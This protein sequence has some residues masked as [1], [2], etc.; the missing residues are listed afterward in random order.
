MLKVIFKELPHEIIIQVQGKSSPSEG[1]AV[2]LL[3]SSDWLEHR[4]ARPRARTHARTHART[5]MQVELGLSPTVHCS[6]V[7]RT[8][9]L[10]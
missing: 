2:A 10:F 8:F 7:V 1:L 6:N 4:R 9:L 3:D 5:Q